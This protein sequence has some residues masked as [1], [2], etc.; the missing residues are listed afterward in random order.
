MRRGRHPGGIG[1]PLTIKRRDR[2]ET[3]DLVDDSAE[4]G[5]GGRV[6]LGGAENDEVVVA[7]RLGDHRLHRVRR[8]DDPPTYGGVGTEQRLHLVEETR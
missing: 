6:H 1:P 2:G 8:L 3:D 5:F 7:L 4:E